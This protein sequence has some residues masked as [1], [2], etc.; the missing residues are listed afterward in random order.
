MPLPQKPRQVSR[1]P[2]RHFVIV[3]LLSMCLI[4]IVSATII[5]SALKTRSMVP[6]PTVTP[7]AL[8][9]YT[10]TPTPTPVFDP[11]QSAVFPTHPAVAFYAVPFA[12]PTGPAYEPTDTM[13]AA[14]RQQGAAS[15]QL[16]P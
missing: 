15:E 5:V 11:S 10:P 4:I 9:T 16:D 12:E 8:A 2:P 6:I 13:L 7:R 14:L 1:H 3:F